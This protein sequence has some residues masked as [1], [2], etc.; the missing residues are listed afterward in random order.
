MP[1]NFFASAVLDVEPGSHTK[2]MIS[3]EHLSL[4]SLSFRYHEIEM[5]QAFN[6]EQLHTLK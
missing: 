3:L 5:I 2:P 4:A 1:A 6:I